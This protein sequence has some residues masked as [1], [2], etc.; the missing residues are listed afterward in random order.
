MPTY[1]A[2]GSVMVFIAIIIVAETM[3]YDATTYVGQRLVDLIELISF[4][5]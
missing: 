3:G 1:M 5:N 4:W 2:I